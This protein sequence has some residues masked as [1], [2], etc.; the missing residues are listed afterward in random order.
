MTPSEEAVQ[1][2]LHGDSGE[3]LWDALLKAIEPND[4]LFRPEQAIESS[5][6]HVELLDVRK[7]DLRLREVEVSEEHRHTCRLSATIDADIQ[8]A[9]FS[10][11]AYDVDRFAGITENK[12]SDAPILQDDESSGFDIDFRATWDD[13]NTSW[14][15]VEVIEVRM[16]EPEFEHR[17]K[18]LSAA[19][20][21]HI[22]NQYGEDA[23]NGEDDDHSGERAPD[24]TDGDDSP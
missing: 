18:R 22:E 14:S 15:E 13:E 20:E 10:P 19:E 5:V 7:E 2:G 8:W 24:G 9:S 1:N 17:S 16:A 4:V 12:T 6:E 21:E 23:P 11:T 3:E